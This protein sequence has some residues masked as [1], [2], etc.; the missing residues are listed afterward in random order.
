MQQFSGTG[1]AVVTPFSSDHTLDEAALRNII[2][3]LIE[4]KVEYFVVLG[5]TGESVTLSAEEKKRVIEIFFQETDNRVP[6]VLGSGGNNTAEI[7]KHVEYYTEKYRPAGILS[8][9]PYYNKPSQEGIYQHYKAV[10]GS[11][12]LPVILYNVPGRT[13][14]N[15]LSQTTLRLAHDCANIVAVKE[16][17]GNFEQFM[18]I[19]REKP[20]G[21]Q[22]LSG[23]DAISIPMISLG[24]EGTISVIANALPREFSNMVRA[25]LEGRYE[26]ARAIHYRIFPFMQLIFREGNPVGI[27]VLMEMLG[28]C[29]S[30]VRLPLVEGS[31]ALREA[32]Q[33]QLAVK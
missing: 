5:T 24:A 9:S 12:D 27:K 13:S 7:C 26:E 11:T 8:V 3:F 22:V 6:I 18:E 4:G 16:A 31:P 23:D 19:L 14:S 1:V 10:A 30:T 2:N 20:T 32:I 15:V 33:S 29:G 28:I 21:F 17:S 25:A